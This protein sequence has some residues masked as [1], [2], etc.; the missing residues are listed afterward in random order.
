MNLKVGSYN[1][2]LMSKL[3]DTTT[4]LYSDDRYIELSEKEIEKLCSDDRSE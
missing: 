1:G 2:V 4:T 3:E